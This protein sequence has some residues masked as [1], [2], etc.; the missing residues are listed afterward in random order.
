M[1]KIDRAALSV[2]TAPD[3]DAE[4]NGGPPVA[5]IADVADAARAIQDD[6]VAI[7]RRIHRR[8]EI[9]LDLPTTQ[10]VILEELGKLGLE[11]AKGRSLSSVVAVIEGGR[12]GPT[13]LLR[14][15]M[16]ALP[17]H[18]DT[19]LDF[20]SEVEGAMHACG[21]DTHVAM[22][23]GAAR[24]L[25]E[26]R[27]DL[28]GRVIL[29]FQPGEEGMGGANLMIDE[30]LLDAAVAGGG[31]RP[32]GALAVHI[33][34]G[35]PTG[36][37]H[38]RPGPEMASTDFIRITV[39]GRGG[40]ASEPHTSLDPIVVAAEIVL[41]LQAMVTRRIDV[42]D[43]AVV[44]IAQITAGTTNNIIPESVF[45]F[46]TIRTVSEKSRAEVR[47]GVRRVAEG[48]AAA[49]GATADVDLEAGYPVTINDP[50]F[51]TFVMDTARDLIGRTKV[52][53]LPAPIMGGED[54]SYVLQQVAGA[55]AFLGARPDGEDPATA[56]RNHSNLVVFDEPAMAVGVALYAAVAI[57]HLTGT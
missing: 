37:V 9:G 35:Y 40:H 30:G 29:M 24:L 23:I 14:A 18:E 31:A 20:T 34:T 53:E 10:A 42:F 57:R 55:M 17:L 13:I 41:A 16:D 5:T 4:G 2:F 11:G 47:A 51:T 49:H 8:P 6:V 45:L 1:T 50:E 39:R 32:T 26:R 52:I 38:I 19:G 43:P 54:F 36:E 21:H 7:R 48:I 15:D 33:H 46:G 12:P 56:P 44:T 28:P 27:A 22:L 3:P 25:Q